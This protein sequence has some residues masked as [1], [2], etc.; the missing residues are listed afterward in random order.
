MIYFIDL[1]QII[2]NNSFNTDDILRY[3]KNPITNIS[4]ERISDLENYCYKWN[5]KGK[6]W[7]DDFLE[8]DNL[9]ANNT[10]ENVIKPI[11]KLKELIKD[12]TCLEVCRTIFEFMEKQ[13]IREN[14][15]KLIDNNKNNG[16][17]SSA[18]DMVRIW[19]M[20]MTILDTL[21]TFMG[22]MTIP[23]KDFKDVICTMISQSNFKSAPQKLDAV[24][25]SASDNARYN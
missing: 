19:D 13:S 4:F 9:T 2:S 16:F 10:R 11:L 15:Q 6:M 22:D 14:I 23:I 20:L 21:C 12:K 7:L 17:E 8:D 3:V 25:F 5:V 24:S 1:L 18:D